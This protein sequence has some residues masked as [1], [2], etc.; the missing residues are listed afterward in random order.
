MTDVTSLLARTPDAP[1]FVWVRSALLSGPECV[2]WTDGRSALLYDDLEAS[3]LGRPPR[4][5]LL[6]YLERLP[7][8]T[9]VVMG[10]EDAKAL[11]PLPGWCEEVAVVHVQ[12]GPSPTPPVIRGQVRIF[13]TGEP[14][15]LSH[16]PKDMF[17]E[18]TRAR[19][20]SPL[21]VA[22]AEGQPVSF[23]YSGS[24]TETW[25]DVSI[26][27]LEPW[28]KQGYA[29]ATAHALI[30]HMRARGKRAV[31]AAVET[32]LASLKLA[33]RLGFTPVARVVSIW[34]EE[35]WP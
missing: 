24:E 32:N 3:V 31:W 12:H 16:L 22:F 26:D 6:A 5:R 9:E 1:E 33:A 29:A 7:R 21:A 11:G 15:D 19:A 20:S 2:E 10:L 25:W 18:F 17:E 14:L 28:R 30:E 34:R 13:E 27:T 8:G 35:D 23:S 4:E